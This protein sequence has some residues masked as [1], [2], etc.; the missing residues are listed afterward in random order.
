MLKPPIY[1]QEEGHIYRDSLGTRIPSVT[2]IMESCG[3]QDF[4][5]V[6]PLKLA[7]AQERGSKVHKMCALDDNGTANGYTFPEEL[8]GYLSAWRSY[9]VT[10]GAVILSTEHLVWNPRSNYTGTFDSFLEDGSGI[11]WLIDRKTGPAHK[12]HEVQLGAYWEALKVSAKEILPP[13]IDISK[14]RFASVHLKV[15]GSYKIEPHDALMGWVTFTHCLN[16][17]NW[18]FQNGYLKVAA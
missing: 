5:E 15:D 11:Y 18:K 6:D 16:L 10:T 17:Y 1:F 2:Q 4:S 8:V 13:D 9:K 3:L 12:A 14:V 7:R